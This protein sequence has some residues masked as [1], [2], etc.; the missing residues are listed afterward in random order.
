MGENKNSGWKFWAGL[1]A[2]IAAG[3]Y[4][5]SD[6]GRRLRKETAER[7]DQWRK[8][9]NERARVRLSELAA[10]AS[11]SLQKSKVTADRTRTNLKDKIEKVS[12][13]AEGLIDRTEERYEKAADWATAKLNDVKKEE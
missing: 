3:V 6:Q 9:I 12:T 2:G 7:V 5:N 11:D 8:D 1:A 4:L 13:T 10:K